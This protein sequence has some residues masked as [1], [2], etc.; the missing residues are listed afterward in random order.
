MKQKKV[1]KDVY[2][3]NKNNYLCRRKINIKQKIMFEFVFQP[4]CLMTNYIYTQAKEKE[5][6]FL[7]KG[8]HMFDPINEYITHFLYLIMKFGILILVICFLF[9]IIK[10]IFKRYL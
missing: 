4:I 8:G 6:D 3:I 9:M 2:V 7:K 5:F 1:S 10:K